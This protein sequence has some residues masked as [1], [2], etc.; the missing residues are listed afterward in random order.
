[1]AHRHLLSRSLLRALGFSPLSSQRS[2]VPPGPEEKI[3]IVCSEFR[4]S[5]SVGL[6]VER[7]L[8]VFL[9]QGWH[10]V[11]PFYACFARLLLICCEVFQDLV[12]LLIRC[13]SLCSHRSLCVSPRWVM[14]WDI[15]APEGF[16][17]DGAGLCR[18]AHVSFEH[19]RC[20][21]QGFRRL[22][23]G[24]REAQTAKVRHG[25]ERVKQRA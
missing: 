8:Q 1:M 15:Q 5:L 4:V 25:S 19:R 6:G 3:R 21:L 11:Q 14:T 22:T 18:E 16:D 24:A 12:P 9:R 10:E 13:C 20:C 7:A 17:G 2:G 23:L